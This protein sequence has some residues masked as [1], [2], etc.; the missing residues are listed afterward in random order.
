MAERA[1][2]V[3]GATG[4][5]GRRLVAALLHE[6]RSVRALSRRPD[7]GLPEP[8]EV[9]E[10]NGRSV[11]E[12]ALFRTDAVVHLAGEPVFGG[13]MT[14]L[15]KRRIRESRVESTRSIVQGLAQLPEP[16][17]PGAFVCAS[18]VGYYGS[19]GD[20][21]LE[22]GAPPG[23]GFLA[24]VCVEWEAAA[25]EA[26][27]AGV[28]SV[29]LRIGIVLAAEGGAL[30]VM[31]IPFRLG[32]GARFG[33]GHQWFPWVHADDVVGITRAAIGDAAYRGP[34]NA[35]APRPVSNAD[36]TRAVAR[37]LRRP[38]L[39]RVPAF[40]LRLAGEE[41]AEELLGSRRVAPRV[42]ADRG[43][44]FAYPELEEALAAEL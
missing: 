30:P 11:P 14:S 37:R 36:F 6:G 12:E 19:R 42:A 39:L 27:K 26:S 17:R 13:R 2:L 29:S 44:A 32:L 23:E 18:A 35:V 43:Y 8:V 22:E 5:I 21:L 16:D 1:V 41:T 31:R 24:D 34:V 25:A 15:R 38:A 33:D 9:L 7:A 28:R 40:A 20:E 4:L 3:T 10:W